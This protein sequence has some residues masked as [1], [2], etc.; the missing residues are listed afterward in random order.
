MEDLRGKE[1][2]SEEQ[3]EV[4]FQGTPEVLKALARGWRRRPAVV[5]APTVLGMGGG[6]MLGGMDGALLGAITGLVLGALGML[7]TRTGRREE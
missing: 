2:A 7:M 3:E 4:D 6:A 5:T 1:L